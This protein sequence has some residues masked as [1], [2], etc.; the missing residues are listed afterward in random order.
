MIQ[1]K[2]VIIK[3]ENV[4]PVASLQELR[5]RM[6]D[7]RAYG[8]CAKSIP[9]EC[10]GCPAFARCERPDKGKGRPVNGG[11]RIT[12]SD[13]RGGGIREDVMACFVYWQRKDAEES[14]GSLWDWIADEGQ[15]IT[16]RGSEPSRK[17]AAGNPLPGSG[18][19]DTF[20]AI[21]VPQFLGLNENKKLV[22]AAYQAAIMKKH[23]EKKRLEMREAAMAPPAGSIVNGE[24][25]GDD[26][27]G[28]PKRR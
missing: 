11:V 21:T 15:E 12:K 2:Q 17:D 26:T 6:L 19:Q 8:S 28:K 18:Y 27:A 1:E 24:T 22:Q 16:I 14:T 23:H 9:G 13:A 25:V 3:P 7:P 5:E 4:L 10:I 20:K